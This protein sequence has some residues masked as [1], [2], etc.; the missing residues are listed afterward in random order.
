M[1][2]EESIFTSERFSETM[3]GFVKRA[4]AIM[5][6]LASLDNSY[7]AS[8]Q[9][10]NTIVHQF[11]QAYNSICYVQ[12]LLGEESAIEI[13]NNTLKEMVNEKKDI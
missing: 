12:D 10:R 8:I 4:K 11:L 9:N 1:Q 7:F 6:Y 2:N 3:N 5:N 13:S